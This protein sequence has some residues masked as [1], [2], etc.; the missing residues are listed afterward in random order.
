MVVTGDL[1]GYVH[2][3]ERDDGKTVAR[4]ATDGS[5]LT[6]QPLFLGDAVLVQTRKGGLYA[7]P[8]P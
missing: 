7:F 1:Q 3:L 8:M 5:S 2:W 6:Q 4:G